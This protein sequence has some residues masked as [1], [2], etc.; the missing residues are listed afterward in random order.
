MTSSI[1]KN[2][3]KTKSLFSECAIEQ[4]EQYRR[5]AQPC[6]DSNTVKVLA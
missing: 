6:I 1:N 5:G 4:I 3:L 2:I